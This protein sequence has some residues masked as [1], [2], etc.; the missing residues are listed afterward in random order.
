MPQI[1]D[2]L[3]SV[4][5][6][7][8]PTVAE[9]GETGEMVAIRSPYRQLTQ[10]SSFEEERDRDV[11]AWV[12]VRTYVDPEKISVVASGVQDWRTIERRLG[13]L[14]KFERQIQDKI[15]ASALDTAAASLLRLLDEETSLR[16][17][18]LA[19]KS[20]L[21]WPDISRGLSILSGAQLC[22]PNVSRIRISDAGDRALSAMNG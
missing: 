10:T 1:T 2:T 17:E 11:L 9:V 22:E 5:E 16:W 20:G 6:S 4:P 19:D 13:A 18:E 21:N 14:A 3:E 12:V 7:S 15:A 8:D